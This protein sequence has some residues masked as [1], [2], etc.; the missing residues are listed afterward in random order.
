[1]IS[2]MNA[3]NTDPP[4]GENMDSRE[5]S[6]TNI[7]NWGKRF[8]FDRPIILIMILILGILVEPVY[9]IYIG[10][11]EWYVRGYYGYLWD[12][13]TVAATLYCLW[14]ELNIPRKFQEL[15]IVNKEFFESEE[16]SKKFKRFARDTFRSK[17]EFY[18]P[19]IIAFFLITPMVYGT[20][21]YYIT[22][23]WDSNWDILTINIVRDTIYYMFFTIAILIAASGVIIV[24]L[25]FKCLNHL[26]T[27]EFPLKVSYKELRMGDFYDLGKFIISVTIPG[28]L[29]STLMSLIGLFYILVFKVYSTGYIIIFSAIIIDLI[30]IVIL[31]RSTINIHKAI[32]KFKSKLKKFLLDEINKYSTPTSGEINYQKICNIHDY[33]DKIDKISD[34]PFNPTSFKQLIITFIS[35]VVPLLLS[36]FGFG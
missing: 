23:R 31:Y 13:F 22:H 12:I 27:E 7:K 25:S 4:E 26:G 16:I 2:N 36:L 14:I 21:I 35:T 20:Y 17:K 1:M 33:Y 24:A 10:D 8:R 5:E 34:W 29:F 15:L 3:F 9:Y 18:I 32:I 30:L 19:L 11:F 28:I 6:L